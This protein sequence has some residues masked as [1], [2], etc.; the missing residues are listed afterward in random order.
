MVGEAEMVLS[1]T[2]IDNGILKKYMP[3]DR[4]IGLTLT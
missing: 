2:L 1:Y 4:I 3:K